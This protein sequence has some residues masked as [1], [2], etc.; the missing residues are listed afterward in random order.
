MRHSQ[1]HANEKAPASSTI[2]PP[3]ASYRLVRSY[4]REV[5][6][7]RKMILKAER[8]QQCL[9]LVVQGLKKLFA[10]EHFVNLLC[11][12]GLDT[13]MP[14]K[15]IPDG[16][17]ST[18]K[19]KQVVSSI[20]E[21]GLIEPLS[22]IQ[23]DPANSEFI[24]LDGHLRVLALKDLGVH[25]A[26]CLLAKDDETYT[27]N[28]RINRLS[29]IQE[30]YM[31]RRAIDR[32][33]S[34]E[35]LARAFGVNLSSINRR[36]NLLEGICPDAIA[37]L[38]DKQFTPDVTRVLRNMKAARQVEAVELMVA[39]NTITV[40]HADAL[41]KATPLEQ[42]NDFKP[43]ERDKQ[44]APIEQIVKLEKEMSQVQTQYKDA[45]ENYGSDLLNLV[46]AKGY[47]TKLLGNDAVKSYITRHEPEILEHFELVVNT[48]S[49]EEAVQQQLEADGEF[50]EPP[51]A[52]EPEQ[53]GAE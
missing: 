25:E 17:M 37:R 21:I 40:A 10:D 31:I 8:A 49:M 6:R 52:S 35:R 27:Y 45:E 34:K 44:L 23:H 12:E 47:L 16:V 42:R 36:I 1:W 13:L 43:T 9:L 32:G 22:V 3:T 46:V 53:I 5:E 48:V 4:Y 38:Q 29:T 41:L 14:S 51:E 7:P 20:H 33:V 19:Y 24:L 39:S 26:P 2:K 30:H 11:T 50:E 15:R 18:R 28:H